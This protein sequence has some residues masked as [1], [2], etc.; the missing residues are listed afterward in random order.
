MEKNYITEIDTKKL[1][2]KKLEYRNKFYEIAD[3][4][5]ED[6][7]LYIA[8][9]KE[10]DYNKTSFEFSKYAY[11]T[12]IVDVLIYLVN[13]S[14]NDDLI[15]NTTQIILKINNPLMRDLDNYNTDYEVLFNLE[16][17]YLD[18]ITQQT[19]EL[20]YSLDSIKFE[21]GDIKTKAHRINFPSAIT[22]LRTIFYKSM[23]Q[24]QAEEYQIEF[25]KYC[26]ELNKKLTNK[27]LSLLK[28]RLLDLQAEEK[29]VSEEITQT[30]GIIE[31]YEFWDT[32][33]TNNSCQD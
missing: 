2:G 17:T 15:D 11:V 33:K 27:N 5:I 12:E 26:V 19:Y 29:R 18:L 32:D 21:N 6:N 9:F 7:S 16:K 13:N 3:A 30:K 10:D 14:E 31:Y 1:I 22:N 20:K 25:K 28:R 8:L 4:V 23:N 24:Q